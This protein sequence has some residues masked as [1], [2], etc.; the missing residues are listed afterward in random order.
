VT[1]EA[2]NTT[3]TILRGTTVNAFGDT[4]D[5][6]QVLLE[7][8]PAILAETGRTIQDPSSPTPRTIRDVICKLPAWTGVLNTDRITD[9]SSGDV[10]IILGV[11]QPPTLTGAPVDLYLQLKRVSATGT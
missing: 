6:S 7:H 1:A 8:V 4:V 3:C 11:T 5:D 2:A 10:F 9:E